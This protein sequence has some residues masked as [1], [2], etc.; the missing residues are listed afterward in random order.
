MYLAANEP[1]LTT[2]CVL[3]NKWS[4]FGRSTDKY[5]SFIFISLSTNPLPSPHT[6]NEASM[7]GIRPE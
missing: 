5:I 6:Y 3:V 4:L 2:G 7:G 1:T